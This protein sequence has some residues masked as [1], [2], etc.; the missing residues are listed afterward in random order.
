MRANTTATLSPKRSRRD[1]L[2]SVA[3]AKD[4]VLRVRQGNPHKSCSAS[5]DQPSHEQEFSFWRRSAGLQPALEFGHFGE[6]IVDKVTDTAIFSRREK[7]ILA[8][9]L[10]RF[11]GGRVD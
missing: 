8:R 5:E 7:L 11:L 6:G 4:E 9:R 3:L 1:D 10:N 2:S